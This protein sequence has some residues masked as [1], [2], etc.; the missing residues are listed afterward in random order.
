M[1]QNSFKRSKSFMAEF[2]SKGCKSAKF[3]SVR[4]LLVSFYLCSS[5]RVLF[6]SLKFSSSAV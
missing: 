5:I 2:V 4:E 3:S 1:D 6:E